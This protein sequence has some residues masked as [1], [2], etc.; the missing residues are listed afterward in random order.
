MR[1]WA[2]VTALVRATGRLWWRFLP[3]LLLW[4]WVGYAVHRLSLQTAAGFGANA[5]VTGNIFVGLA[6]IATAGGT[7]LMIHALGP[8]LLEFRARLRRFRRTPPHSV[9]E[10]AAVPPI[11]TDVAAWRS[12]LDTLSVTIG[13]FL[14]IYSVWGMV[15]GE[16]R[17]LV[18]A[19][20]KNY[21]TTATASYSI[22]LGDTRFYL[23]MTAGT[24][25]VRQVVLG[26]QRLAQ[27]RARQRPGPRGPGGTGLGLTFLGV[28]LEGLWVY[29]FFVLAGIVVRDVGD[30]L[31]SR[32]VAGWL[33]E[34]WV[35]ITDLLPVI[36]N[37]HLPELVRALARWLGGTLLPAAGHGLLLPLLW[38]ALTA[39]VFG[40]RELRL[41]DIAAVPVLRRTTSRLAPSGSMSL[42]GW[43][44]KVGSSDLRTKYLPVANS[45]RML[46]RSGPRLLGAYLVLVTVVAT[47]SRIVES[48]LRVRHRSGRGRPVAQTEPFVGLAIGSLFTPV[49]IA[50]YAAATFDRCLSVVPEA[51]VPMR[52]A[53]IG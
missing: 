33:A 50:L 28:L 9:G 18:V 35:R 17:D 11:P 53:R 49:L 4:F 52:E 46:L 25:A 47:A 48:L 22:D 26:V 38:L 23:L 2:E 1:T 14:A 44:V 30:W 36:L 34:Q 51:A 3:Q 29:L 16:I 43:A 31:R 27:R 41:R 6:L 8:G 42:L 10:R 21:G 19:N 24:W 5:K 12:G 13:P 15:E 7:I 37:I 40:W 32:V 20:A 39:T 45:L